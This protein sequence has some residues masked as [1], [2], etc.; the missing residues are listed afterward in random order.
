MSADPDI[1]ADYAADSTESRVGVNPEAGSDWTELE[2]VDSKDASRRG[3]YAVRQ[4]GR[5]LS[6][7]NTERD[8]K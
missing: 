8:R 2:R 3:P 7:N 6:S 5:V 1:V 4:A